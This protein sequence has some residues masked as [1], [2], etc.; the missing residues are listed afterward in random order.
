[1]AD[2]G[3][4]MAIAQRVFGTD[5]FYE[6]YE[7]KTEAVSIP[8]GDFDTYVSTFTEEELA[9]LLNRIVRTDFINYSNRKPSQKAN[10][11]K[12]VFNDM[13]IATPG[14]TDEQ[15]L[16]W[17]TEKVLGATP[18]PAGVEEEEDNDDEQE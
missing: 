12:K 8:Y 2:K 13:E 7:G 15:K 16:A 4:K 18:A 6:A 10:P 5:F 14:Q 11:Y 3:K 9:T 1:M 17:F